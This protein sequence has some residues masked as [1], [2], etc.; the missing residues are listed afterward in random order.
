MSSVKIA[1]VYHSRYG[2]TKVQAEAVR[3]GVESISGV[4]VMFMTTEEAIADIDSLDSCDGM[5]FGSPT[6]MGNMSADMKKFIEASVSKWG[7]QVWRN[8]I[9]GG[10]SNSSNFY[11]DKANT[12][13]GLMTFAMQQ[14]M[15]WVGVGDLVAANDHAS[16]KKIDGPGANAINRVSASIGPMAA[17]FEI[18]APDAPG[19]GDLATARNYGKRIAE[20]TKRFNK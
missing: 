6:Y 1:I 15:I 12:I 20:V 7:K 5:I 3:E 2:H 9:A 13:I 11:G 8:K 10:F 18:A 14:G 17:S 16:M 19:A 4:Q